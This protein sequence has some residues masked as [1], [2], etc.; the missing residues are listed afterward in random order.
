MNK[1]RTNGFI[2]KIIAIVTMVIDHFTA[3]F[4]LTLPENIYHLGRNIGRTSFPLFAYM[5][6]VGYI[7][8]KNKKNYL[9]R[10]VGVGLISEV[11][12]DYLL[13]DK[14]FVMS[15]NNIFFTLA[16]GLLALIISGYVRENIKNLYVA[17]LVEY[18][19]VFQIGYLAQFC[20][21]DYGFY[22]VFLIYTFYIYLRSNKKITLLLPMLFGM[23]QTPYVLPAYLLIY[24]DDGTHGRHLSKYITYLFYPAHILVA[25][26][27]RGFVGA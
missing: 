25:I 21:T 26:L 7:H 3:A 11:L 14:F 19:V 1:V 17:A 12:F 27:L 20:H 22:G 23:I 4:E 24:L 2:L 6:A 10:L 18:A 13:F 8:T 5:I 9:L 16:L 15:Y